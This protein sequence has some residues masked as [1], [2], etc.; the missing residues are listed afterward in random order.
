MEKPCELKT[1]T[2]IVTGDFTN[3]DESIADVTKYRSIADSTKSVKNV[4]HRNDIE[5]FL[6]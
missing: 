1:A 5:Y 4:I 6:Y 2:S 3:D